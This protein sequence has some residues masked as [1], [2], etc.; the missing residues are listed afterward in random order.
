MSRHAYLARVRVLAVGL[1]YCAERLNRLASE[2]WKEFAMQN[3]FDER[4]VFVSVMLSAPLLCV[5]FFILL[6]ALRGAATDY[7]LVRN[8]W[9]ASWGEQGYIRI[10]RYGNTSKGEPCMTDNTPG[11][12]T[13]CKGGPTSIQVC[14]LCGIMSDSSYPTGGALV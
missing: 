1:I 7:W 11:D 2:N 10:A 14:G 4:G 5:A 3:Y 8:S 12:G 6:N 13:A 9:G